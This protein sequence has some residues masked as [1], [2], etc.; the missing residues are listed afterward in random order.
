MRIPNL[1]AVAAASLIATSAADPDP[2]SHHNDYDE[3]LLLKT[4]PGNS[5]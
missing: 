1:L 4:L 5:V 2:E 3:Q